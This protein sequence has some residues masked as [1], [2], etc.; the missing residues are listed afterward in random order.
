MFEEQI[1]KF[2]K[3]TN[4][5]SWAHIQ[6][7][8]R[9]KLE[10]HTTKGQIFIVNAVY[11][12]KV[13]PLGRNA[14]LSYKRYS[15]QNLAFQGG[16]HAIQVWVEPGVGRLLDQIGDTHDI[17]PYFTATLKNR[18]GGK[19]VWVT[20]IK[21]AFLVEQSKPQRGFHIFKFFG[22]RLTDLLPDA[23][24]ERKSSMYEML[25]RL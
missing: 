22:V 10:I 3:T 19:D 21:D 20:R 16:G 12:A 18:V 11:F 17:L 8:Y 24:E 25:K 9:A 15:I 7:S 6:S 5:V 23:R 14:Y 1:G 2:I 4:D 13:P